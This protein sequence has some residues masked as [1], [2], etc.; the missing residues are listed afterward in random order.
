MNKQ[1][2]MWL[3]AGVIVVGVL[4][5]TMIPAGPI[6]KDVG[7]EDLVQ[8]QK[9]GAGVI[10]VRTPNEFAAG[11]LADAVNVPLDQLQASAEGW[12]K[13]RPVVLYCS[14][15][16]RSANAAAFLSAQGFKTVYNL[17]D[18]VAA[19]NGQVV[20]GSSKNAQSPADTV[21]VKTAGKPVFIDFAGSA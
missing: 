20:R 7:N 9:D 2:A 1:A 21:K 16:A 17:K 8:L 12:N 4:L 14:T 19:W 3:G 6:K 18:G 5:A 11:H 15:G 13:D 10:D